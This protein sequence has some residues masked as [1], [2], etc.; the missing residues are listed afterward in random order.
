MTA[1]ISRFQALLETIT[2]RLDDETRMRAAL[3][4]FNANPRERRRRLEW[5]LRFADEY[6]RI[7]D[8]DIF[9]T[10]LMRQDMEYVVDGDIIRLSES[11]PYWSYDDDPMSRDCYAVL[12]GPWKRLLE[13]YLAE[14]QAIVAGL[15]DA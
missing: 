15:G 1:P 14:T 10:G 3:S 11:I 6:K 9:G 13:E 7:V 4:F 5:L 2:P 8:V 12:H